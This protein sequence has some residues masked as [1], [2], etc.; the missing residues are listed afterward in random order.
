MSGGATVCPH[1]H[2]LSEKFEMIMVEDLYSHDI[3]CNKTALKWQNS[4][5]MKSFV[6]EK[7][8]LRR[9][10][11]QAPVKSLKCGFIIIMFKY[12]G[13]KKSAHPC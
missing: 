13:C 1:V 2:G 9:Q 10:V 5:K 11:V 4:L 12:S 8:C 7:L 3:M 6:H